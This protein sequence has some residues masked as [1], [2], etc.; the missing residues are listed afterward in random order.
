[1]TRHGWPIARS[2]AYVA[3]APNA[4]APPARAVGLHGSPWAAWLSG[5][6]SV[7]ERRGPVRL[8]AV[9]RGAWV[10]GRPCPPSPYGVRA[11]DAP[12]VTGV[13]AGSRRGSPGS[14]WRRNRWA[15]QDA[16]TR[17][18][19]RSGGDDGLGGGRAAQLHGDRNL[20]RQGCLQLGG[21]RNGQAA[22][23]NRD[24]G[25]TRRRRG[26]RRHRQPRRRQRTGNG[27][28]GHAGQRTGSGAS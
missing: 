15:G 6:V 10:G 16:G 20:R 3:P 7:P 25:G 5:I 13:P 28:T 9:W 11:S 2:D 17:L 19:R 21:S 24:L 23:G 27:P 12:P 22:Q 26:Y 8:A 4:R 14:T 1:M 18:R